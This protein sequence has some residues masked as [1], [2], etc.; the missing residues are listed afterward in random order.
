[1][2]WSQPT[3]R[4]R[5]FVAASA[6]AMVAVTVIA[7]VVARA[8]SLCSPK[9]SLNLSWSSGFCERVVEILSGPAAAVVEVEFMVWLSTRHYRLQFNSIRHTATTVLSPCLREHTR[10]L[11]LVRRTPA[12]LFITLILHRRAPSKHHPWTTPRQSVSVYSC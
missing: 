10:S 9:H 8:T 2:R 7:V 11:L 1:M 4:M 5:V 6:S 3:R 12:M